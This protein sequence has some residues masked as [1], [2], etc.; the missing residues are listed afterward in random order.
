MAG[1]LGDQNDGPGG[2]RPAQTIEGT[3]TEIVEEQ[4]AAESTDAEQLP[5][6]GEAAPK[7][8]AEGEPA[9]AGAAPP[10]RGATMPELRGFVTHLTAGLLGGLVGVVALA[11]F[12]DRLPVAGSEEP[13]PEI[14]VL[15][16]RIGKLEA[17]SSPA[18]DVEAVKV[19]DQR[20]ETLQGSVAKSSAQASGLGDRVTRLEDSLKAIAE[21]AR[22]GGS[23]GDAAALAEQVTEAEQRLQARIDTALAEREAANKAALETA[24]GEIISLKETVTELVA[25]ALT[26]GD[27]DVELEL[28]GHDA[29]LAKLE[30]A[31]AEFAAQGTAGPRS[32]AAAIAFANLRAAVNA[33]RPYAA[34]LVAMEAAQA[35]HADLMALAANADK[36]IPTVAEL[37]RSFRAAREAS[38]AAVSPPADA[39]ILE[40]L[41]SSVTSAVKI[42]RID[43]ANTGDDAEAVLA[44]AETALKQG[45]LAEAVKEIETLSG[46]SRQAMAQWLGE[47]RARI[48]ADETLKDMEIALLKSL[49]GTNGEPD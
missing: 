10:R 12:W 15:E 39:S 14:A 23:V 8:A 11:F 7:G 34:E 46:P 18:T 32:A 22:E 1:S 48:S 26:A 30:A 4:S 24:R 35:D 21:T 49:A 40:G 17:A 43:G 3:A 41:L 42:R 16:A 45:A 37:T 19:L 6:D 47:A 20:V 9:E 2:K 31:I 29:R 28:D 5:H 27:A 33:G 25:S 13:A 44:R 36:G 38:L